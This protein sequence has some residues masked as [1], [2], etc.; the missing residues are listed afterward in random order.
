[1]IQKKSL[2]KLRGKIKINVRY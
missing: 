2:L 1:M